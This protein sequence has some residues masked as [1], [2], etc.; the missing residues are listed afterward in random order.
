VPPEFLVVV[1]GFADDGWYFMSGTFSNGVTYYSGYVY[2]C[3]LGTQTLLSGAAGN[4]TTVTYTTTNPNPY[5]KGDVVMVNG[6][7]NADGSQSTLNVTDAVILSVTATSFTVAN[8]STAPFPSN[9]PMDFP[10]PAAFQQRPP[11]T[12]GAFPTTVVLPDQ[13]PP[14]TLIYALYDAI[15][16]ATPASGPAGTQVFISG[17]N[18]T[19]VVDVQFGGV[20]VGV[21]NYQ[22]YSSD[23]ILAT[24]PSGASGVVDVTVWTGAI[25][26]VA[27]YTGPSYIVPADQF[28][29]TA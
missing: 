2:L 1:E 25:Q 14:R 3:V 6:I 12:L 21:G 24:A 16:G 19:N 17:A 5:A 4:G 28:T 23:L 8:P 11:G 13:F 20:S 26:P 7:Y 9:P 18:F 22:I 27:P 15:T 29:Y 10:P